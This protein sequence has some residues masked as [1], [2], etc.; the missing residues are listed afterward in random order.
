MACV[1][2][3]KPLILYKRFGVPHGFVFGPLLF[4]LTQKLVVLRKN[5]GR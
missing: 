2:V 1:A 3:C 4:D 5:S